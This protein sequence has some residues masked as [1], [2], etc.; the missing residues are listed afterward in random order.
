MDLYRYVPPPGVNIPIFVEPFPVDD[1][2]PTE[3][4]IKWEVK[5]LRNHCSGGPSGIQAEHLKRCL[6]AERKGAK[7]KTTSGEK[8]TE[9]KESTDSTEPTEAANWERAVDLVQTA[10]REGR[11][12]EEAM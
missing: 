11:L 8:T 7:D 6:V 10:F 1:L 2:V 5:H 4:K 3:D 9:G 12:T